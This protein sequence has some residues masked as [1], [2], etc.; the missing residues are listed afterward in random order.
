MKLKE[1]FIGF[2]DILGFKELVKNAESGKLL[3]LSDLLK[4]LAKLGDR[5]QVDFYK[6]YG[7]EICPN[8]QCLEKSLDFQILQVSDCAILSIEISPA[9]IINL[10]HQF[11]SIVM[12]LMLEGIL[13]RGYITRGMIFHTENQVI[14]SGYQE[15]YMNESAVTAF[16]KDADERGTP[17]VELDQKVI[18]YIQS[19]TDAC[20]NKMYNRFVKDDGFV[21][22]IFPFRAFSHSFAITNDF[23]SDKEKKSN[24]NVRNYILTVKDSIMHYSN[25]KNKA[26]MKKIQHYISALNDQLDVC[27]KTD[28]MIDEIMK[29]F[30][31]K[32]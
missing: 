7:P 8:S 24:D 2:I 21:A 16:K 32:K 11:R 15:A 30:P 17:F 29:P 20:I 12:R 28:E 4:I 3:D 25:N 1:K 13:C 23:D 5:K 22:A 26:A 9:G 14:G 18:D 27:D 19:D 10:I 31:R 6:T